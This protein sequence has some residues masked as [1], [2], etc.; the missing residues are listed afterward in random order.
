MKMSDVKQAHS[1]GVNLHFQFIGVLDGKGWSCCALL[2]D[3]FNTD[4]EGLGNFIRTA[5]GE[6]KRHK[7]IDAWLKELVTVGAPS[8]C[9]RSAYSIVFSL[10]PS[11]KEPFPDLS[12]SDQVELDRAEIQ[13]CNRD[14]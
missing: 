1:L 12:I 9:N 5:R 2:H 11:L 8:Q 4:N 10:L 6:Y 13:F 3:T 14:L 7:T